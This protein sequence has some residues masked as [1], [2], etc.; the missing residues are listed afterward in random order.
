MCHNSLEKLAKINPSGEN[1]VPID[2]APL[3]PIFWITGVIKTPIAKSKA[4]AE[5]P[6]NDILKVLV[7]PA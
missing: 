7:F 4:E 2:I 5:V 3:N 1:M 6:T